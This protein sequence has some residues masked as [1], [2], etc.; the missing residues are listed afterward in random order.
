MDA[1]FLCIIRCV[2]HAL[3]RV[4]DPYLLSNSCAILH[5]LSSGLSCELLPYTA[6][7]LVRVTCQLCARAA[8]EEGARTAMKNISVQM[9]D[10]R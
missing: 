9:F 6:E 3:F 10:P 8:K 4:R 2:M 5:N 7:R 1:S